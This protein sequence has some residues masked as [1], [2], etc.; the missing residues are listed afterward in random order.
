MLRGKIKKIFSKHNILSAR[1]NEID[2]D[3]IFLDS[4]N[5]PKFDNHQFEGR[6]ISPISKRNIAFL[7]IFFILIFSIFT[8]K[9]WGLQIKEGEKYSAK[10]ENNRLRHVT[11]FSQRGVVY[12][13]NEKE[14]AWNIFKEDKEF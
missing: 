3:Q 14:L 13:R 4:S 9:V 11:V 7:S 1:R 2:P 10:S 5:L 6:I 12:D 8:V